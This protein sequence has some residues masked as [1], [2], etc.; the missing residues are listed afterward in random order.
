MNLW[1]KRVGQAMMAAALFF[2][3]C[4][5]SDLLGYK[6]K[7]RFSVKY[8]EVPV[9]S[10]IFLMDSLSTK[11]YYLSSSPR[12]LVG[13]YDDPE[14][15]KVSSS[16]YTQ[17]AR[18]AL[19]DS[20]EYGTYDSVKL[21]LRFDYSYLYGSPDVT[22]QE[23]SIYE[24]DEELTSTFDSIPGTTN[25]FNNTAVAVKPTPL[26]DYTFTVNP[27]I[28]K[29]YYDKETD[30]SYDPTK[31]GAIPNLTINTLLDD[32]FGQRLFDGAQRYQNPAD[33]ADS[34]SW[35]YEAFKKDF[36][37]I[38]ITPVQNDKI[39]SFTPTS[40]A[41]S[42]IVVY[43]HIEAGKKDSL[44]LAFSQLVS[45]NKIESDRSSTELAALPESP[46]T[47]V[48]PS[49]NR[50][51]ESGVGILT[52]LDFS[53]LLT[54]ADT[55]SAS[56]IMISSAE[57]VISDV[58]DQ[59]ENMPVISSL[60]LRA[61]NA[62]NR[63]YFPSDVQT[64]GIKDYKGTLTT[65]RLSALEESTLSIAPEDRSGAA[66]ITMP[67]SSDNKSYSGFMTLFLQEL[68]RN[69]DENPY[70]KFALY[71]F[72][73][74]IGRSVNRVMFNKDNIKLRIYYTEATINTEN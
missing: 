50:Y 32:E 73:P 34:I 62:D 65:V 29:E 4:E 64:E 23:I 9:E 16:A 51:L 28:L 40:I 67:Y 41:Y 45:F 54:F 2:F 21:Q 33:S 55:V 3:S 38:A 13:S 74:P 37:G 5:D 27:A 68:I 71:P 15:G 58:A 20:L 17:F 59:P 10:S 43:F 11:N 49:G 36:K 46:G 56:S 44:Q 48:P 8:I 1:V 60:I 24:L 35:S 47:F 53:N 19:P 25:Y 14:L 57:L 22:P 31:S 18:L 66:V 70:V 42:K 69:R 61:V 12:L 72:G 39:V 7:D 63:F 6:A 30:P 52:L 26:A